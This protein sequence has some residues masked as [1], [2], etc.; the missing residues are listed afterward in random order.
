MTDEL[1]PTAFR[2]DEDVADLVDFFQPAQQF[3][4]NV[5]WTFG[6]SLKS[7]FVNSFEFMNHA[8]AVIL[9]R[10]KDDRIAAV[11]RLAFGTAEWFHQAAPVH[12]SAGVTAT[13]IE[14]SDA[15]MALM[16][17]SPSWRTVR[18]ASD[19]SG[20]D[21]LVDMGYSVGD[22]DEVFMTRSLEHLSTIA[23]P[24]AEV[25]VRL[26]DVTNNAEVDER[27]IAQVTA[28]SSGAPSAQARAWIRR[29]LPH[30]LAYA[31]PANNPH[32]IAIDGDGR[33]LAFADTFLDRENGIGEFEPVGTRT[34]MQRT[35][36]A[37]AVMGRALHDMASAALTQAVV[38]TGIDNAAAIA[39]YESM[40]FE[41]TDRRISL[42]KQRP[43]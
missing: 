22:A 39:A 30:Q 8:P 20:I 5:R 27:A 14:H 12:R 17:D 43:S 35:G 15:A 11:S 32:V 37:K 29:S 33:I 42:R 36:L 10:A 19:Q 16:T 7:A 31:D 3:A 9:W 6:T 26:L 25:A 4:G 13:I 41:I 21:Q 23:Q 34:D 2:G 1:R 28:F 38:R 40:G 24:S 18:Y